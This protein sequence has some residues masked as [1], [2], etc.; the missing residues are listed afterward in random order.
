M[1]LNEDFHHRVPIRAFLKWRENWI[2]FLCDPEASVFVTAHMSLVPIDGTMR[3]SF[4]VVL[5][6]ERFS[7]T[8]N[9]PYDP[10]LYNSP[11]VVVGPVTVEFVS[12]QKEIKVT[13]DGPDHKVDMR[14]EAT[15]PVF[16]Y[17]G[18]L[19]ANPDE[20][21][22]THG[23][24]MGFGDFRHQNQTMKGRGVLTVKNG[25]NA[26]L[27]REFGKWGYRDHSWGM[28]DDNLTLEHVWA[29]MCF[30]GSTLHVTRVNF[31][32][33]PGTWVQEGYYGRPEGNLALTR[34]DATFSGESV[35]NMP[36]TVRF[37]TALPDG[38][39]ISVDCDL[40]DIYARNRFMATRPGKAGYVMRHN[41]VRAVRT[42]TGEVGFAMVEIGYTEPPDTSTLSS[43]KSE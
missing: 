40:V 25:P 17:R 31:V 24:S 28:R 3:W 4:N 32:N 20:P 21:S 9:V 5:D 29:F 22:L 39:Q 35:D 19:E 8:D 2:Y 10:S 42:D 18:C 14:L 36:A 33:N 38:Q 30:E 27:R 26:G 12:P 6:G 15:M 23:T 13:V 11:K 34:A 1:L 41:F 43:G 16:D 37:D 7:Y